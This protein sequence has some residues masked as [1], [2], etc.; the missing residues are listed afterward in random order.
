MIE[1]R[2]REQVDHQIGIR[3]E[4]PQIIG[5]EQLMER[6]PEAVEVSHDPDAQ[7]AQK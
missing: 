5:E 4:Q 3:V 2:L 1:E 6:G 7:Q